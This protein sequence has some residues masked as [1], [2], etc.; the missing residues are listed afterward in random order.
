MKPLR[1]DGEHFVINVGSRHVA[2]SDALGHFDRQVGR[3]ARDIEHLH[4]RRKTGL[5]DTTR[6]PEAVRSEAQHVVHEIVLGSHAVEDVANFVH[7]AVLVNHFV[8]EVDLMRLLRPAAG[9]LFVHFLS[10]ARTR[11]G[12]WA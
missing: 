8:A 12:V 3:T 6:L 4:A 9:L 11:S 1:T 10:D 7:L 5:A 2:W